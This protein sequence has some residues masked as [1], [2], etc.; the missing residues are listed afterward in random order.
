MLGQMEGLVGS[1]SLDE[2]GL[3]VEGP[4]LRGVVMFLLLCGG[5][6]TLALLQLLPI[7]SRFL[8]AFLQLCVWHLPVSELGQ[9]LYFWLQVGQPG[10]LSSFLVLEAQD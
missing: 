4:D 10:G 1:G 7:I 3:S 6:V 9:L 8:P 2:Y 5:S